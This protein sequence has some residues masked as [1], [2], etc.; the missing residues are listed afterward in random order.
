MSKGTRHVTLLYHQVCVYMSALNYQ[1]YYML[2]ACKLQ[3]VIV[4]TRPLLLSVLKERLDRLGH[5]PEDW[6]SIVAPT[7]GL[8]RAGIK[9]AI[10]TLQILMDEDNLLGAITLSIAFEKALGQLT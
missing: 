7:D 10:K 8:I 9:S 1:N 4:A 6:Q 5:G 2:T 3:C